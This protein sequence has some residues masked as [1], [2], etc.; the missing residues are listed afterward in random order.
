MLAIIKGGVRGGWMRREPVA[1]K[2]ATN[3]SNQVS[4]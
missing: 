4:S 2:A 1:S 3:D